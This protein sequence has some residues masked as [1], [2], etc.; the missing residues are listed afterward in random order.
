MHRLGPN[1]LSV[2]KGVL[3]SPDAGSTPVTGE[4]P[5][6]RSGR[7][8]GESESVP[9]ALTVSQVLYGMFGGDTP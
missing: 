7:Q 1:A 6:W 5:F 3:P 2:N 4:M 8:K 9:L